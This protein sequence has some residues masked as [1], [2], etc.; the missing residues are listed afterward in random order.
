M[1][2]LGEK[3]RV[4]VVGGGVSGLAAARR[5]ER[6]GTV[7]VVLLEA[8]RRYGGKVMTVRLAGQTIDVG[9]E[10]MVTRVPGLLELID[11]LGLSDRVVSPRLER[12]MIWTDRLR[13]LPS[14]LLNGLPSGPG[15]L[16]KS[17]ILSPTGFA[18]AGL[19][20]VL[21]AHGLERDESIGGLVRAR[22]GD[23][24]LERLIDPL[25]GGIHAGDTDDLS[26]RSNAP[27]LAMA[28]QR[29]GGLI[30]GLRKL[31]AGVPP[32]SGPIFASF[33]GGLEVIVDALRGEL[34]GVESRTAAPVVS[35]HREADRSLTATLED[36]SQ[37]TAD[38]VILAVPAYNAAEIVE[39]DAPALAMELRSINYASVATIA[40]AFE[41]AIA[42]SLPQASGFLVQRGTG[43]TITACTLSGAKWATPADGPFLLKCSAGYSRNE[44]ALA[45]HED[46]LV[47]AVRTDLA[48]ALGLRAEPLEASV[49]RFPR[50]LP[51][52]A[53][54]HGDRIAAID[55][56]LSAIEGLSLCGAA[57]HGAGVGACLADGAAAAD[58]ALAAL[59]QEHRLAGESVSHN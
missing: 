56:Q 54:G 31:G 9:A 39:H 34:D 52:Y 16:L 32:P 49:F 47:E 35:V 6:A 33:D 21:P 36:G 7:E 58:R 45:L 15:E 23:Q 50:A 12:A 42:A 25:L 37:L 48:Q 8:E 26:V 57:Y 17:G 13:P 41:P 22:L 28:M 53:V 11:E 30:R 20:F 43:H 27:M 24:F 38:R 18:R 14:G 2:A 44:A 51:Q 46:E 19:D 10:A 3:P 5:L 55:G 29:G 4:L 1:S 40:L 59:T